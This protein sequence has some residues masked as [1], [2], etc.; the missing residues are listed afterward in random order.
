M[1][2]YT[3]FR[4]E[5]LHYITQE[6]ARRNS[7]ASSTQVD[8]AVGEA[9]FR[10]HFQFNEIHGNSVNAVGWLLRV[11]G[12]YLRDEY[13]RTRRLVYSALDDECDESFVRSSNATDASAELA[14][15]RTLVATHLNA[16]MA[17]AVWLYDIEGLKPAEIA[18]QQR[19]SVNAVRHDIK[20]GRARLRKVLKDEYLQC[21]HHQK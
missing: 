18:E 2:R 19:R 15:I 4:S 17:E 21:T 5:L 16:R 9:M 8:D 12:N 6:V 1:A 7:W 14:T 13:R 20:R 10:F 3:L 11:A